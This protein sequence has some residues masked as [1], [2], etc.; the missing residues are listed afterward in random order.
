MYCSYP[1]NETQSLDLGHFWRFWNCPFWHKHLTYD[2]D[3]LSKFRPIYVHLH[4]INDFLMAVTI[5][6]KSNTTKTRFSKISHNLRSGLALM[7]C[8]FQF[9]FSERL[10]S[11]SVST[12]GWHH[13]VSLLK[14]RNLVWIL[15]T[16][17]LRHFTKCSEKIANLWDIDLKFSGFIS[18]INM[19]KPTKFRELSMPRI[20]K[21]WGF[22]DLCQFFYYFV[23]PYGHQHVVKIS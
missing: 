20:S 19:E 23:P 16:G 17:F 18:D 22:R 6:L 15:W 3:F 14:S 21:N 5:E 2:N 12:Y 8:Q 7:K 10:K 13:P 4:V 11:W 9:Y 1:G